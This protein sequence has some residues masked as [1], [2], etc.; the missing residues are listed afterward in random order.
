MQGTSRDD[1]CKA[2]RERGGRSHIKSEAV[3]V[4]VQVAGRAL[5][6]LF[7]CWPRVMTCR[8][9]SITALHP[10]LQSRAGERAGCV[11]MCTPTLPRWYLHLAHF[12][13]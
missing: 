6:Y 2:W 10:Q 7:K 1:G 4:V 8:R 13:G 9:C 5:V 3:P 12:A 11:A